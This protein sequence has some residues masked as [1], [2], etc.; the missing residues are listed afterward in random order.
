MRAHPKALAGQPQRRVAQAREAVEEALDE[1]P[2]VMPGRL[3]RCAGRPGE[4]PRMLACSGGGRLTRTPC[5]CT[6]A[7]R[8]V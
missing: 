7:L 8:S 5:S 2:R 1:Q 4:Q 3:I 6:L